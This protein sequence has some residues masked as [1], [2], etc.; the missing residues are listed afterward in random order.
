MKRGDIK[1]FREHLNSQ[2]VGD[3]KHR[4]RNYRQRTRLYG[5]YL[6]A[7]DREKFD[8]ELA[9]WLKDAPKH[10]RS[11]GNVLERIG[12]LLKKRKRSRKSRQRKERTGK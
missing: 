5:D 8:M 2:D 9:E 6:Y 4:H 3:S 7:Q 11:I 12:E 10:H 1:R